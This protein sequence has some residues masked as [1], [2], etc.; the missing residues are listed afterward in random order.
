ML[1]RPSYF[2]KNRKAW[3]KRKDL[4]LRL[5]LN[6]SMITAS[7]YEEAKNEKVEFVF[8]T[9]RTGLKAPHFVFYVINKLE[10][11]YGREFLRVSGMKVIT[12]LD[13][14]LQEKIQNNVK[15]MILEIEEEYGVENASVV[16]I[17]TETGSVLAMVGS[18]D[19]FD[20][21]IDGKVNIALA[22]R[23][24]GSS[25][26]PIVYLSAFQEGYSPETVI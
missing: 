19:Y 14:E 3:N 17:E 4:V 2:K 25:F 6:Q 22:K 9:L 20:D 18:R 24:P 7:E 23:Q 10:E 12:T 26:K 13:F 5:M 1:P 16:A 11:K 8:R 21:K 15:D